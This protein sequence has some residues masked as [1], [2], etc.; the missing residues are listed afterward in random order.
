MKL[1]VD[2]VT[3]ELEFSVP[4]LAAFKNA[5]GLGGGGGGSD[6]VISNTFFVDENGTASGSGAGALSDP[7]GTIVEA[8]DEASDGDL[9]KVNTGSYDEVNF[10]RDGVSMEFAVGSVATYT[11]ATLG[12]LIDDSTAH[13]T[14]SKIVSRIVADVMK[15]LGTGDGPGLEDTNAVIRLSQA[16]SELQL[17]VKTLGTLEDSPGSINTVL[18]QTDGKIVGRVDEILG[19][20]NCF[21][22]YW[23]EKGGPCYLIGSKIHSA[24]SSSE[25]AVTTTVDQQSTGDLYL[26]G[27]EIICEG[28]IAV[29][30]QD[31]HDSSR[32]WITASPN[33]I[34]LTNAVNGF[35]S[36]FGDK[37]GKFYYI[38]C[39]KIS[40]TGTSSTVIELETNQWWMDFQKLTIPAGG[41][42]GIWIKVGAVSS[43]IEIKH[44]ECLGAATNMVFVDSATAS[45]VFKFPGR[46]A[47]GS[48]TAGGFKFAAGTSKVSDS[49]IDTS[50]NSSTATITKNGGTLILRNCV[51]KSHASANCITAATAQTVICYNCVSNTEPHANITISPPGGLIVDSTIV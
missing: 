24:G 33:I 43:D 14:G 49:I 31:S 32:V 36:A 20:N 10:G 7:F 47:I 28:G 9:V 23:W 25:V 38:G 27:Y 37:V 42:Y 1:G 3:L 39:G 22:I 12:G 13:G 40:T 21:P 4:Q 30:H 51:L 15:T 5:N 18:S 45:T 44:I 11:G 46:G 35:R 16:A 34:G 29:Q 17:D 8:T 19:G 26:T 50:A 41:A 48:A 6:A 2:N